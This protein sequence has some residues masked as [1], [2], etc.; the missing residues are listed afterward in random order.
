MPRAVD[1]C[2]TRDLVACAAL[3][4]ATHVLYPPRALRGTTCA[5]T[6]KPLRGLPRWPFLRPFDANALGRW[7]D[8]VSAG[9]LNG[10][11]GTGTN[12]STNRVNIL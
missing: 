4:P 10:P 11:V 5:D 3:D 12:S 8:T 7:Q 9:F 2:R 1:S 6:P